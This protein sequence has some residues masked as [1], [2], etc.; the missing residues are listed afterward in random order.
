MRMLAPL[1]PKPMATSIGPINCPAGRLACLSSCPAVPARM[2]RASHCNGRGQVVRENRDDE[3][4]DAGKKHT[5]ERWTRLLQ[6][7]GIGA[8]DKLLITQSIKSRL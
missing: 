6:G 4:D 1:T 8:A 7:V 3:D 5:P 2:I